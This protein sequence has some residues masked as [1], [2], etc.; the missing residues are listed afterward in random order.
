[1]IS[2][3]Q[4]ALDSIANWSNPSFQGYNNDLPRGNL[5]RSAD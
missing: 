3:A 4:E 5:L 2:R 1:M